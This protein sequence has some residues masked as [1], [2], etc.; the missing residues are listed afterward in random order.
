MVQFGKNCRCLHIL[1]T[2][3]IVNFLHFL[4]VCIVKYPSLHTVFGKFSLVTPIFF[5][6]SP[7]NARSYI[8]MQQIKFLVDTLKIS[9]GAW[10]NFN[11]GNAA[12]VSLWK[13][14]QLFD[15]SYPCQLRCHQTGVA[16]L[17]NE[18]IAVYLGLKL[19]KPAWNLITNSL[20]LFSTE[21]SKYSQASNN[22]PQLIDAGMFG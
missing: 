5:G 8:S 2:K 12:A 7:S 1:K 3:K 20:L 13:S 16:D 19:W 21:N 14:C 6:A 22:W 10:N 9:H 18:W 11:K 4:F 15:G 17:F